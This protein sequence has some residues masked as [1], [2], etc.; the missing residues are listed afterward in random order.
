[1]VPLY[2]IMFNIL[3]RF[4]S[5]H[6][7]S[8]LSFLALSSMLPCFS[9]PCGNK[10]SHSLFSRH[11][12]HSPTLDFCLWFSFWLVPVPHLFLYQYCAYLPSQVPSL[13]WSFILIVKS[14]YGFSF[15]NL[16]S[17]FSPMALI[18]HLFSSSSRLVVGLT[19]KW[20]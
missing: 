11:T 17:F 18:V 8:H 19:L 5:L 1:M 16:D 15:L 7:L 12:L 14:K 10:L 3:L 13:S 20:L 4:L 9:G 2:L 6:K